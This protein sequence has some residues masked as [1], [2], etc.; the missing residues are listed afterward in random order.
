MQKEVYNEIGLKHAHYIQ[1]E[2]VRLTAQL[3][4]M[5]KSIVINILDK[6]LT[7]KN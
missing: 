4:D 6:M 3:N 5:D 2:Q 7:K 1:S